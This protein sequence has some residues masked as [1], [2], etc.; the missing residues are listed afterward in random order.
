MDDIETPTGDPAAPAE[1][2]SD[3]AL[4]QLR[5][6]ASS[7][8][9]SEEGAASEQKEAPPAWDF[10]SWKDHDGFKEW[11][12]RELKTTRREAHIEGQQR[13]AGQR[14]QT[15]QTLQQVDAGINAVNRFLKKAL[16]EGTL[17]GDTFNEALRANAPA[18]QALAQWNQER[19][20]QTF[21]QGGMIGLTAAVEV[22]AKQ[23]GDE[24]LLATYADPQKGRI[25]REWTYDQGED[26]IQDFISDVRK[27]IEAD[28]ADKH[29]KR[30]LADGRKGTVEAAKAESRNGQGP[31]T[32][33]G[34]AGG[35]TPSLKAWQS[36]T[37]E[38]REEARR[39]DPNI[40]M[41]IA[42]RR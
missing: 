7:V 21:L 24:K 4:S 34:S 17:D 1:P 16:D 25:A 35:G 13:E 33:E 26:A 42:A 23:V 28:I 18:W 14:Q 10:E 32:T 29:Y 37:L 39:K 41:K 11:R 36:M 6:E 27:K 2:S 5:E 22:I 8:K 20:Q 3:S 15:I 38:Q 40:E 19:Q 9:E 31:S 30:G 12:E